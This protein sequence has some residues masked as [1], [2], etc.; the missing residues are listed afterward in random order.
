MDYCLPKLWHHPFT[1]R[2]MQCPPKDSLDLTDI[3]IFIALEDMEGFLYK[4]FKTHL[5]VSFKVLN[6]ELSDF[7][8]FMLHNFMVILLVQEWAL[9]F[10][11]MELTPPT[12]SPCSDLMVKKENGTSS[13][14]RSE[15]IFLKVKELHSLLQLRS[16]LQLLTGLLKS[17]L[18]I[19]L[20]ILRQG[21]MSANQFSHGELILSQIL[22]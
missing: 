10:W 18:V 9:S 6:M 21:L 1:Q 13:N 2:G 11:G 17:V 22:L 15:I 14:T 20:S 7:H 16:S 19:L 8:L 3:S 4:L 5:Q 12:W